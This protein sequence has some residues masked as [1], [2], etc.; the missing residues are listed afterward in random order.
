MLVP[1]GD[2]ISSP[3]GS[4]MIAGAVCPG[5][6]DEAKERSLKGSNMRRTQDMRMEGITKWVVGLLLGFV[7]IGT[8]AAPPNVVVLFADDLGYADVGYHGSPDMVTPHI[9]S[10]AKNGVQFSA[11][12]VT[13]PV[14]GPSRAGL[15]TGIY[16]NRCGAEDNPGPYKVRE[17]VKIGI[18]TEMQTM[19]ERMKALGYVTGMIGKSHT[20]N[21]PEF[22]PNSSGYDEFFGFINGASN[23]LL[24]R[25]PNQPHNPIMRQRERVAESEYLTDAFGRE[26]VAFI[27]RHRQAPFFL[28]V[29]FNAIHGPMQGADHDMAMFRHIK[30]EKRRLAVAMNYALDRNVGRILTALRRHG[31]ED[32]TLVFFLSDNG[33]KPHGN[34]SLNTPLRGQKSE[35]WDGGIRVPFCMQWPS[36][37]KGGQRLDVPVISLDILPTVVES[38]G[39]K[40]EDSI[41]GM[42][43]VPLVTGAIAF[44][45][46][47]YLYWRFNRGWV[48]RDAEWKLIGKRDWKQPK[49]FRIADDIGEACD[50]YSERPQIAQRLQR[51]YDA[52]DATLMPKLWGWDTSMPV[53]DPNMGGE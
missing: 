25:H 19:S 23:Y 39:G 29:P 42:S 11:G 3:K 33:G 20:G 13:A 4:N 50:L 12:Y 2:E 1:F 40:V 30:D 43:L 14:C 9:D 49:L 8:A 52:W 36:R 5:W 7:S 17:D 37:V 46:D 35:L 18:P 34:G 26:A 22:H 45:P 27:E 44:P 16:Q 6:N 47:R 51:A 53:H 15:R 10:I 24:D 28:Y 41:D 31:L 48:I 21:G 32:N 38:A